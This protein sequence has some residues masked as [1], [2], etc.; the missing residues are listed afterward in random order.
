MDDYV[1]AHDPIAGMVIGKLN[2]NFLYPPSIFTF[3][4]GMPSV[5]KT[6]SSRLS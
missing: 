6:I 1:A 4:S 3:I 5:L 2:A